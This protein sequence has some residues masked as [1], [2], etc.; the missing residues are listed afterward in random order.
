MAITGTRILRL[1]SL[2]QSRRYWAGTELADRL[3]ISPRTLRRD[4]DRLRDL[5][6]PVEA[7]RGVD[8]GYQLAAGAV[9]P[10]LLL[11]NDEAVA[12]GVG[13]HSAIQ[14]GTVTG[15]E[16]SSLRALSKVIQVM[17][18]ALR[19][20][21]DALAAMTIPVPWQES[22]ASVDA[23]VL[24]SVAQACRDAERLAFA[25]IDH[26]GEASAREVDPHRLALLGRR[27]YLVAWDL[28][29]FDWRT[30]RLDRLAEPRVTGAHAIPRQLPAEDAAAF[31]RSSIDSVTSRYQV[32]AIIHA[33]A[34]VIRERIGP[35]GTLDDVGSGQCRFRMTSDS[36]DW[37]TMALGN[38]IAEFEVVSPPEL[39]EHLR[40]RTHQFSRALEREL[41]QRDAEGVPTSP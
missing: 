8:G 27:W 7:Q 18:S 9:L 28:A 32:E 25:Y 29:R 10:P 41:G 26:S 36:L 6:Y 21:I 11:D 4:I 38:A 12:I 34:A 19:R 33:P 30:F 2:L 1:L 5:G 24:V 37:P 3:E 35:W 14:A 13:L 39:L 23:D 20:R 17:P 22:T 15:I 16:D 40:E 31:V